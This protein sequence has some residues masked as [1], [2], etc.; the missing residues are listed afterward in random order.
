MVR[1]TDVLERL[2]QVRGNIPI[3]VVTGNADVNLARETLKR[4]AFDYVMKP[5]TEAQL[6]LALETALA[7]SAPVSR[8]SSR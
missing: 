4:G 6:R 5:F 8:A 3:I 7:H 1:G 2:K